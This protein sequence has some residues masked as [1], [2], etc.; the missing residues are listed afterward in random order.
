M[1]NKRLETEEEGEEKQI[2]RQEIVEGKTE[3]ENKKYRI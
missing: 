3:S 1:E 2:K